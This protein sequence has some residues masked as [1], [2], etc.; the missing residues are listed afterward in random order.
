MRG[1][2]RDLYKPTVDRQTR[3]LCGI[4]HNRMMFIVEIAYFVPYSQ[5]RHSD[6]SIPSLWQFPHPTQ[7]CKALK[8]LAL[9]TAFVLIA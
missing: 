4:L 3:E 8:R 1:P 9:S 7:S 5:F 6:V 2:K